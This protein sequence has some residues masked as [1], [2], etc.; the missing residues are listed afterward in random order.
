MPVQTE[1]VDLRLTPGDWAEAFASPEDG[2]PHNE[3]RPQILETLVEILLEKAG[4]GVPDAELRAE[5]LA[6]A[7]VRRELHRAWPMIDAADLVGDLWTVPAYLRLCAPWLTPEQIRLLGRAEPAAWTRADLPLLDAARHRLGD[8]HRDRAT[9]RRHAARAAELERRRS[10]IDE[11][12]AA[13]DDP[14]GVAPMLRHRDLQEA[15]LDPASGEDATTTDSARL[16][17]PFAH[18]IV[19]EAQELSDAEWQMILRRCPSGSLTV[20]GD[21]A[22]ARRDFDESWPDRLERVGLSPGRISTVHLSINYRTPSE[23]MAA[24]APVIRAVRPDANVP[25]SVRSSGEPVAYGRV[26]DLRSVVDAWLEANPQGVACVIGETDLPPG[27]IPVSDRVR[28]L[29]A[30]IAKGLE[31]D[32]V[33]LVAPDAPG[34]G[35]IGSGVVGSGVIGS[36]VVD[37][38]DRYVA[39]TRATRSLTVLT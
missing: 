10:V 23:V 5:L 13:S 30:A 18:V 29:T 28:S 31:F 15:L 39:M 16:G 14:E 2:T 35:V 33:V 34:G 7:D 6:N 27:D 19:D 32:L 25:V 12:I 21:R 24:A 4:A 1:W 38:V 17:G 11:V 20:V 9:R 22:Q 26:D 37:A 8:A 36:G 3:A